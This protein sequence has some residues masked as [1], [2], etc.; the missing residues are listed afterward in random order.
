MQ[1]GG[2]VRRPREGQAPP[3]RDGAKYQAWCVDRGR[4]KPLPYG[5]VRNNRCGANPRD[6]EDAVP[7]GA[8]SGFRRRGDSRIARRTQGV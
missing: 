3:L 6:V 5:T 2:M 4:G 8:R 1:G 7:Y